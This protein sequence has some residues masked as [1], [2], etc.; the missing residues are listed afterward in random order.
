MSTVARRFPI[1]GGALGELV[2]G[3]VGRDDGNI[4]TEPA[5]GLSTGGNQPIGR[6]VLGEPNM[7]FNEIFILNLLFY[8][9][10]LLV[11]FA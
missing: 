2:R 10:V 4:V 8:L 7:F 11:L 6:G 3:V 9:F 1:I 5:A